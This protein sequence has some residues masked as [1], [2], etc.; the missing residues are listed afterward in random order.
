MWKNIFSSH[1]V[2]VHLYNP[3]ATHQMMHVWALRATLILL[4]IPLP[5]TYFPYS[6]H[7]YIGIKLLLAN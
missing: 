1:I 6:P 5:L 3:K 4:Q 7:L 2:M